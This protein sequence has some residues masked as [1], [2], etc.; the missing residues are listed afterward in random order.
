MGMPSLDQGGNGFTKGRSPD[1]LPQLEPD[2]KALPPPHLGSRDP[3]QV[4]R[5]TLQRRSKIREGEEIGKELIRGDEQADSGRGRVD[6]ADGG[7][8]QAL[9]LPVWTVSFVQ[10]I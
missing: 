3:E 8:A 7:A 6:Q 2:P 5:R 10:S 1:V 9:H 4:L